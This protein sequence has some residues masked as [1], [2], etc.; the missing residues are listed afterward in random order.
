MY[1]EFVTFN[2]YV[3]DSSGPECVSLLT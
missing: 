2:S 3:T 1:H